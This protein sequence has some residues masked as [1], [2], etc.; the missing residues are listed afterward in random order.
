MTRAHRYLP[1]LLLALLCPVSFAQSGFDDLPS[2]GEAA[3]RIY[4]PQQDQALGAA[5]MRELRQSDLILDD[6]ATTRYLQNLGRRLAMHSEN[7]GHSF[8]FFMVNDE[9]INAFAGPAGYIGVN[10]GLFLAAETESELAAV[11]AHE[12]A[13]VTQRHLA[14]AFE[15]ADKLSLPTT[16]AI[17]AAILIGTQDGQAGAAALTAASAASLQTQINFTRANEQEAD[18]VGIQTLADSSFDPGGM[19]RFFERLQ[20]NSRL[21]GT[22]PPEFLSTHPVTSNRIA[23]ADTRAAALGKIDVADDIDFRL[24]RAR[25][26][27]NTYTD[28]SQVLAD[29][30]RYHGKS[31][32]DTAPERYEYALLLSANDRHQDAVAVLE[33]LHMA[34]PDRI[35]YR[36]ALG[37]VLDRLQ[38][39]DRARQIYRDTLQLYP[40]ELTVVLPFATSLLDGG[41]PEEAYTLLSDASTQTGE[42][43]VFRLLAQAAGQTGRKVQT[44]TAM[45]EYYL[46]NG[47]TQK[48]L[49]QLELAQRTPGLTD[50][51][52]STIQARVDRLKELLEAEKLE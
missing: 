31:G 3:G 25:L 42:P 50:Y 19:G 15:T 33:Q 5:F 7:P 38:R 51:Q 46:L 16:A 13:H 37:N 22:Q 1:A 4:S 45:G 26:R 32:G 34:D 30:L 35:T 47:F 8:S 41:Q 28:P 18:R 36:V 29:Y 20:K 2:L 48:A 14:R 17:L 10:V 11:L 23:E 40:G 49:D 27:V 52:A 12:I 6:V 43:Q 9:R 44:H 39:H 24:V 21:Y